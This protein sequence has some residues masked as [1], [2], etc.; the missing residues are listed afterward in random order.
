MIGKCPPSW[1]DDYI[2]QK[3]EDVST[4]FDENVF[5]FA[6]PPSIIP[7]VKT[8]NI[9]FRNGFCATCHSVGIDQL[10][11][12][13]MEINCQES[14]FANLE[15]DIRGTLNGLGSECQVNLEPPKRSVGLAVLP[16]FPREVKTACEDEFHSITVDES[17]ATLQQNCLTN[18]APLCLSDGTVYKNPE[19]VLY[20][21]PNKTFPYGFRGQYCFGMTPLLSPSM[22][23]NDDLGFKGPEKIVSLSVVFDFSSSSGLRFEK[24]GLQ[25]EENGVLCGEGEVF[26]PFRGECIALSCPEGYYFSMGGCSPVTEDKS[27]CRHRNSTPDTI[28]TAVYRASLN[29]SEDLLN[30]YSKV[31]ISDALHIPSHVLR[32]VD[33]KAT[34]TTDP[35]HVTWDPTHIDV[36]DGDTADNEDFFK[37]QFSVNRS[38]TNINYLLRNLQNID[39]HDFTREIGMKDEKPSASVR[40]RQVCGNFINVRF[41][42]GCEDLGSIKS[43]CSPYPIRKEATWSITEEEGS[44]LVDFQRL[45]GPRPLQDVYL[46]VDVSIDDHGKV[47]VSKEASFCDDLRCP[48]LEVNASEFHKISLNGTAALQH[49]TNENVIILSSEY[50]FLNNGLLKLCSSVLTNDWAVE[51]TDKDRQHV[52][53]HTQA[54]LS[55][56]GICLSVIC[57]WCTILIYML[58]PSL[59][60]TASNRLT[61]SFCLFLSLSQASSLVLALPTYSTIFCSAVAIAT[62]YLWLVTFTTTSVIG[63]DM[64]QAFAWRPMTH[65]MGEGKCRLLKYL[66]VCYGLPLVVIIPFT[67]LHFYLQ[68]ESPIRYGNSL[69]CWI[70]DPQWIFYGIAIPLA[71]CMACNVFFF[72][73]TVREINNTRQTTAKMNDSGRQKPLQDV[74]VF[75]KVSSFLPLLAKGRERGVCGGVRLGERG[76]NVLILGSTQIPMHYF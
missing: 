42:S 32:R 39:I 38:S 62:H 69:I 23:G 52:N 35:S 22:A 3:C 54:I 1:E 49:V 31:C 43:R 66:S 5:E 16:C 60:R 48:T 40:L 15:D 76:V 46:L 2:R 13:K 41:H 18:L 68:D 47:D 71:V 59:R 67:S 8:G 73:H 58:F 17:L 65:S 28:I 24:E 70:S 61:V 64:N 26:D 33:D 30:I 19:C 45:E 6:D 75:L 7:V 14:R 4:L 63:F 57:L 34:A 56:V 51:L 27:Y 20:N 55:T 53:D 29:D 10:V 11:S 72:V 44:V 37:I 25:Y 21:Y 12:W 9:T 74:F 50:R 36:H